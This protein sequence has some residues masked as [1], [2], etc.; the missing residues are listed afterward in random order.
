MPVHRATVADFIPGN[1]EAVKET[2]VQ[3]PARCNEL[4]LAR[5]FMPGDAEEV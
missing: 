5:E 1:K 3:A 2:F 4:G